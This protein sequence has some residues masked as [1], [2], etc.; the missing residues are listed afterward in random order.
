VSRQGRDAVSHR[1]KIA[2]F[3]ASAHA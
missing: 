2:I 1:E 3:T